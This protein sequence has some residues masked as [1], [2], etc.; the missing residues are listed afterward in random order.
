[1]LQAGQPVLV[2]FWAGWCGPCLM[3]A[4]IVDELAGDY[5]GRM[6]I[7]KLDVDAS[8]EIAIRYGVEGIPTLILF[9]NGAEAA[10]FVGFQPKARLA[11]GL[12]QVLAGLENAQAEAA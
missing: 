1:V 2:D 6:Q 11:G 8:P 9:D 10:R 7:A 5:D 3:L 12:D 4:P